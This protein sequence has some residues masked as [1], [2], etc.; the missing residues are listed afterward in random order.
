MKR[1]SLRYLFFKILFSIVI[2]FAAGT[3]VAQ[4]P[5]ITSFAPSSGPI[6]TAVT[7]SGTNFSTTPADNIVW[8]GAV[9]A[10][11]NSATATSLNVVVPAG[12]NY[13]PITVTLNGLTAYSDK[14][15]IATLSGLR[16]IDATAFASKVD[17]TT[18]TNPQGVAIGD[19]DCDGKPDIVVTNFGS[20]F[21]SVFRN[22]STTGSITSGSFEPKVDFTVGG[23][24]PFITLGDIDGDGKTDMVVACRTGNVVSVFRNS[25]T[26]GSI[27]AASFEPKVDFTAGDGPDCVAIGDIDSDGKPDLAVSNYNSNTV[28]VFRNTST[29]GTISSGSFAPKVDLA[30]GLQPYFVEMGDI[31]KDGKPDLVISNYNSFSLSLYRNK[32]TSGSITSGSFDPRVDLI[33]GSR[34]YGL[35]IGDIDGDNKPDISVANTDNAVVSVFKNQNIPGLISSYSFSP[36]VDFATGPTPV[37]VT[38]S[39]INGDGKPDLVVENNGSGTISILK[40]NSLPGSIGPGSL[41]ARFDF[42]GGSSY[43]LAVGD[44]DCDGK[45]DIVVTNGISATVS[46]L[47]NEITER[48]LPVITSFTPV[49]GPIGTTITISGSNFSTTPENNY[50]WFGAVRATVTASTSA[51]LTV[52]VP[53]GATY[54]P[55]TVTVTGLTAYS[56][57]PFNVTI[58]GTNIFDAT[59]LAPKVDFLAGMNLSS[60]ALAD[61]DGDGKPDL[62]VAISSI[63]GNSVSIYRNVST[64]GAISTASFLSKIDLSTPS[65]PVGVN[66]SDIDGDGKLDIVVSCSYNS[67]SIF[68]NLC[69]PGAITAGS[70]SPRVDLMA[71][72]SP[73]GVALGDLD[74]DGKPDLA[75]TNYMSNTVSIFRNNS[76]PGAISTGSFD[77]RVDFPVGSYPYRVAI[78]DIDGDGKPDLAVTNWGSN[79]VSILKNLSSAGSFTLSSFATKVDFFTGTNPG[80]IAI[81]DIDGN[82]KQDVILANQSS[83]SFSIFRNKSTPGLLT[84]SS[85]AP[86]VDFL[87]D[88]STGAR[89]LAVG[90]V[91]G[92]G[93]PDLVIG[94]SFPGNNKSYVFRNTSTLDTIGPGSFAPRLEFIAGNE[95][96]N[97]AIGDIDGDGKTDLVVV[98]Y[99]SIS[100][101]RNRLSEVIPPLITSFVPSSGTVGSTLNLSG[102]GFSTT[103]ADNVVWFG[104]V[105]AS[106]TA[107]T[108][109]SL[110]VLVPAGATYQPIS[111]T[112]NGLT[113]YSATPFNVTFAGTPTI[114]ASSFATK[115]DFTSAQ[116]PYYS[117]I[118]DIDADGKPDLV[119]SN[120]LS[121]SASNSVSVFRNLSTAGTVSAGSFAERIDFSTGIGTYCVLSGDIDG[122]GRQD[123]I[124]SNTNSNFISIY[125]NTSN[126]GIILAGSFADRVDLTSPSGIWGMT[127]GD[128]DGDGRPDLVTASPSESVISIFRN[129]STPGSINSGSF[130]TRLDILPGTKPTCVEM[131]DIDGDRKPDIS[132]TNQASSTFS[133]IKNLSSPGSI[134]SG[135]FALKIDFTTGENPYGIAFSDIDGDS[136]PDIAVT[137]QNSN[138][139]SLFRNNCLLGSITATSFIEKVDFITGTHPTGV[140]ISDINGDGK[141]DVIV[142][143]RE[144]NYITIFRNTSTVGSIVSSSLS[145]KTDITVGSFTDCIAV[146]DING[147]SKPDLVFANSA[148]NTFSVL[149]NK[150]GDYTPPVITSF[151]PTSGPVGTTVAING[152]NFSVIPAGN[153]V[154]F[155]TIQSTVTS[156][157]ETQLT[158]IVPQGATTQP[159]YVTVNMLTANS[160]TSFTVTTPASP[161]PIISGFN[162]I[163]GGVGSTVVI[164]GSNFSTNISDNTVKFGSVQ[165][166]VTSATATQLYVTVPSGATTQ[167]IYV[168]VNGLTA[169]TLVSFVIS[170]PPVIASFLPASGPVGTTVTI[171]GT[172]F[173]TITTDNIVRFGTVQTVVSS[174]TSTQLT[175]IVPTSA[176]TQPISVT[177]GGLTASSATDFTVTTSASDPPV[178]TSFSPASGPIGTTVTI[179]GSNFSSD[180]A[181]NTVKFGTILATV[182]SAT[183]GQL[184]VIVP[185]VAANQPI[186]VTVNGLT[187]FSTTSFI[188]TLPPS[189]MSF[190]PISGPVGTI[191]TIYGNN[192][193]PA[194][195]DNI[196]KFGAVQAT[197]TAATMTQL[198][199]TVPAISISQLI[200]VTVNGLTANSPTPFT[201]TTPPAITSFSPSSGTVGTT[202]NITG[203]A[204]SSNIS[205]NIVKFGN[206]QAAVISASSN[207][208]AVIVP[209]GTTTQPISVTVNGLTGTS[210]ASFIIIYP[211]VINS[212]NPQ[213]GQVGTSV[214]ISGA[215]FSTTA[216]NNIVRFGSVQAT[217]NSSTD[218]QINV[219]VPA[220]AFTQPISVTV[221]GLTAYSSSPFNIPPPQPPIIN[222]FFPTSGP[223]G[224]TVTITGMNF[225]NIPADNNVMFGG[226]QATVTAASGTQLTVTVPN[227]SGNLQ[228]SVTVNGLT[229]NSNNPFNITT[230]GENPSVN[231]F[232]FESSVITLNGDGV[233]DRLVIQNFGIYGK[234]DISIY[235]SRG[236]LIFS[237]K[238]YQNDWDMTINGRQLLTGGYFYVAQTE[239]GVFRGSFS[240]LTQF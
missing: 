129:I 237:Q 35:A 196:V 85:L 82:G 81:A 185:L 140:K 122:D 27:S 100:V 170:P 173:S 75:V 182:T 86:R 159:I 125:R 212:F 153:I 225:S 73:N 63:E 103:L 158:V 200:S 215:N 61:I 50:V 123:L 206:L 228:I 221:N 174:A 142:A 167:P 201:V 57:S 176:T 83:N 17:F 183:P 51:Q 141:P 84:T 136:K 211:P 20:D 28:S 11:V 132:F 166:T 205:D 208:L 47:H 162:P 7:I 60:V 223:V 110:S 164:N 18:G 172:N 210:V 222:S 49:S 198:T 217:V 115:V 42:A 193:G 21:V 144:S 209:A 45:Q 87:M 88:T 46:V 124:I 235:N 186:Y 76:E 194:I 229:A 184:S 202:V 220:G 213:S 150:I 31:D 67:V 175:V 58:P 240:I 239:N 5:T 224:T 74:G 77:A 169:F 190:S 133:V 98:N 120:I 199:V 2:A 1:H 93:K 146:G 69:S 130:Q 163:S 149:R 94:N 161:P 95:P 15:F 66:V 227:A 127:I 36:K 89:A 156:S 6:G 157:S 219:T 180:I 145:L 126:S 138:T 218:A 112:V 188:I 62:I 207:Q 160:A 203:S 119:L 121:S 22:N 14:P 102:S 8:F 34:P 39:D 64:T 116:T 97:I 65:G 181:S 134:T 43:G 48:L 12:A 53:A 54:Q 232:A 165:A 139:V 29:S 9:K 59:S 192:F 92:D 231:S 197:V 236:L 56:S 148:S 23:N 187:A 10:T 90:D 189:I 230:E 171:N 109:V 108:P 155:G 99:S 72:Y 234:C 226:N 154:R 13:Q 33:T 178:I 214:T 96:S 3:L 204:F 117:T 68:R 32:S 78:G 71:S 26:P 113:A 52:I 111:V 30:T 233:N 44:M 147:D 152:E 40:N 70:F 101:L 143:N 107:A 179:V 16:I 168:T 191:V 118:S 4:V 41:S 128:V 25:S 55:F 131:C 151:T 216:A 19:I 24:S 37:F 80:Q 195:A 91:D 114:D 106:V 238:D 104:A 38:L 135:S 177:T 137:N 79:T 105:R